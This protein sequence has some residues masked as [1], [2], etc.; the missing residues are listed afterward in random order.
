MKK[1]LYTLIAGAMALA[2]CSNNDDAIGIDP[3]N[4]TT[5]FTLGVDDAITRAT[6]TIAPARYVMEVWSEDGTTAENVFEDGT[7][8]RAEITTGNSFTVVLDQTKAYTCLFWAD[9]NTAYDA[10]TLK[11]IALK[12]EQEVTEAYHAK[13]TVPTGKNP[14]ITVS[15][16]RAVAKVTLTE[17]GTLEAGKN[18]TATYAQLPQFSVL[19]GQAMGTPEDNA[20]TATLAADALTG[21]VAQ[22][23][24]LATTEQSLTDFSF[25]YS[26]EAPKT[27]SNVP[28][29]QNY[30]TNIKGSYSSLGSFTFEIKADDAWGTPDNEVTPEADNVYSNNTKA[31][32]PE[33]GKGTADDPFLIASASNLKWMQSLSDDESA[34]KDKH[35]KLTTDIEVTADTWKP[36]GSLGGRVAFYGHFDGDGHTITGKLTAADNEGYYF[37]FFGRVNSPGSVQNLTN[38]A[39]VYAPNVINV[40][41]IIGSTSGGDQQVVITNCINTA[42][43][44]GKY[45]VAG[46]V[47]NYYYGN[48]A[49][50]SGEHLFMS[51]CTNSGE[52]IALESNSEHESSAGGIVATLLLYPKLSVANDQV[53]YVL[54]NCTNSG[55]VS[56]PSKANTYV[57]GIVGCPRITVGTL[58]I[59][60]CT[61]KGII[62]IGD[63]PA[64]A[65]EGAPK[66]P[67]PGLI[68]GGQYT[69]YTGIAVIE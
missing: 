22:F 63:I 9:D 8:N 32:D 21:Q 36:I 60:G 19:D 1:I 40:G 55:N 61:N 11:A 41:G 33:K 10:T 44:T 68:F 2:S 49:I 64:T 35:F 30:V 52:I 34:T 3:S 24:L 67:V 7:K 20:Y 15:L 28:V 29:Q 62:K 31:K 65:A 45:N 38:A 58:K 12:A 26:D 46:I 47:G 16:K 18:L 54:Q 23:Y 6:T 4:A 59:K 66:T 56:A 5:V 43:V 27:V 69:G 17:T 50:T 25:V 13:A 48:T 42:K 51:G 39:E 37:G 53:T 14:A 57:G